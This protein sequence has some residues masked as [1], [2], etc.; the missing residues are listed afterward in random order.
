MRT[1]LLRFGFAL[2]AALDLGCLNADPLP[3]HAPEAG[4]PDAEDDAPSDAPDPKAVCRECIEAPLDPG[5]GC[6]DQYLACAANEKCLVIFEC[7]LA[8]GCTSAPT[9]PEIINCALPCVAE[10]GAVNVGDPAVMLILPI[11][12]CVLGPCKAA[13]GGSP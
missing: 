12:P 10:A 1:T 8:K 6:S 4:L 11:A 7:V 9:Q 3:F 13:C 5:P 2:V